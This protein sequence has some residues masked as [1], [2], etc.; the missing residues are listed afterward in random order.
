MSD[1]EEGAEG[2]KKK[3]KEKKKKEDK[4]AEEEKKEEKKNEEESEDSFS[5]SLIDYIMPVKEMVRKMTGRRKYVII[6]NS[7]DPEYLDDMEETFVRKAD[8]L[9][10][11]L[12]HFN[13]QG[14]L[15]GGRITRYLQNS[16]KSTEFPYIFVSGEYFGTLEKF[17]QLAEK[18]ALHNK[19]HG[20]GRGFDLQFGKVTFAVASASK[21]LKEGTDG[22]RKSLERRGWIEIDNRTEKEKQKERRKKR[23]EKIKREKQKAREAKKRRI[24]RQLAWKARKKDAIAT[25]AKIGITIPQESKKTKARK[26]RKKK[27]AKMAKQNEAKEKDK[28]TNEENDQNKEDK[29]RNQDKGAE[30]DK[31]NEKDEEGEGEKDNEEAKPEENG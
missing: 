9:Y 8:I 4:P 10:E 3:G 24:K 29:V 2:E 30:K 31:D 1:V 15:Q 26:R 25:L 14:N 23:A 20:F 17:T 5:R 7:P 6:S 28:T 21:H 12:Y 18:N 13:L 11:E 22:L 16:T 19:V 27:A